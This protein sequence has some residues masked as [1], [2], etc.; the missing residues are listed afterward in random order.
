MSNIIPITELTVFQFLRSIIIH[1]LE[2]DEKRVM[3]F[4]QKWTIPSY[5]HMFVVLECQPSQTISSKNFTKDN[6]ETGEF[7]EIQEL[8]LREHINIQLFSRNMEAMTRKEE[9]VA[10]LSSIYAQQLQAQYAFKILNRN[11]SIED[12]SLL[13]GAAQLFRYDIPVIMSTWYQK[14]KKVDFYD[15]FPVQV[16]MND[17]LPNIDKRFTQPVT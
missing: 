17:G 15:Q 11:P 3:I 10:A 7:E 1:E 2:I 14:K 8:N 13:E 9:V 16:N 12:L 4:N 5:E 6:T